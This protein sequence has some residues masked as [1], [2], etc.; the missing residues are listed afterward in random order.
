MWPLWN[1]KITII[2]SKN[3]L[4]IFVKFLVRNFS[5]KDVFIQ[6]LKEVDRLFI[7]SSW[8]TLKEWI[9]SIY[10]MIGKKV[11]WKFEFM[12]L[13]NK[14]VLTFKITFTQK[15]QN[16]Q[17]SAMYWKHIDSND[18]GPVFN[19]WYIR[20]SHRRCSVRKG[21]LRNL[22]KFTETHLCQCLCLQLC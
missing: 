15:T 5:V 2:I 1:M 12:L 3:L 18:A 4:L 19:D 14:L 11:H 7:V 8:V 6:N 16:N 17:V 10:K 21:V 9:S 13:S 20:S 22:A